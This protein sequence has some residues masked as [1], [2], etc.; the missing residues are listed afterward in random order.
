MF[1]CIRAEFDQAIK[2]NNKEKHIFRFYNNIHVGS[3]N[4]D[5]IYY[6]LYTYLSTH[7]N[8]AIQ[9]SHC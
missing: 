2:F 3:S 1:V 9:A 6:Y 7:N 5:T 4:I 8:Y